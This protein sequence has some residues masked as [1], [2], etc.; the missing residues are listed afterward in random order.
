MHAPDL[1]EGGPAGSKWDRVDTRVALVQGGLATSK[2][3]RPVVAGNAQEDD[4]GLAE[5]LGP[6]L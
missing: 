1:T 2:E 4:T 6:A 3:H 5:M